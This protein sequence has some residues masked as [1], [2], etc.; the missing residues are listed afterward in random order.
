MLCALRAAG[1]ET[2]WIQRYAAES[3]AAN[4][5]CT[6]KDYAKCRQH[7]TGLLELL[8]G[9]ADI[10][11]RLAKTEAS[12]GNRDA[13]LKWLT[14]FS[15]MKVPFADPEAEPA[16]AELRESSEF[17]DAVSRLNRAR[18]P[19]SNSRLLLTL[20]EKDLVAEDIAYDPTAGRF[21]ISSV[22][23][24]K[25]LALARD[26]ASSEF[27]PEGAP[28]V[29]AIVALGVD[30]TRRYLWATT[31]AI[32][33]N[34]HAKAEDLGRTA[35]L[36]FSLRDGALQKRY[37]LPRDGEHELGDLTVSPDGDVF[38][39][40]S[41]GPVY[42]VSHDEDHLQM[43]VSSGTFRSPQ[44][45]ALSMDGYTLFVP[46]YSRGISAVDL[47][48]KQVRLLAHPAELSLAGIDGLYLT[49]RAILAVQNGVSPARII[50]MQ[51]DSS[52]TRI[53]GFDVLESNWAGLGEP[54]HGVVVGGRFYFIANSGW[55]RLGDD[56]QVKPGAVF[57]FPAVR[58]LQI[59]DAVARK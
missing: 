27:L 32:P 43:L 26:G 53:E 40:D 56:G 22:R 59:Q 31:A 24:G 54:T 17:A 33:G 47:R 36:R 7:L 30:A 3:S 11:Y 4:Q 12:L 48:T 9:R 8:N 15:R 58:E 29:W 57:E 10:V 52:L 41:Q 23:H 45:P 44:T 20:P 46:D 51:L 28:D 13:A 37:D 14:L 49:G 38:V 16:F 42:W 2:T 39:S 34:V 21:Y 18:Q 1:A 5:A 25:I 35:L 55:D 50:R 6:A 19:V